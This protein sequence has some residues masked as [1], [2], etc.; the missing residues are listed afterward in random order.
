MK[1][2]LIFVNSDI[3]IYNFKKELLLALIEKGFEVYVSV[4]FGEKIELLKEIG[5]KLIETK[6]R[7]TGHKS[8][9]GF[10]TLRAVRQNHKANKTGIYNDPYRKV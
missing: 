8:F 4:P 6:D 7:Q 9:F 5:V 3:V 1:K 10:K 2:A